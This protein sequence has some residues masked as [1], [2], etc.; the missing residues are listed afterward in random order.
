MQFVKELWTAKIVQKWVDLRNSKLNIPP[1]LVLL[2]YMQLAR[3]YLLCGYIQGVLMHLF[4]RD[5]HIKFKI[6]AEKCN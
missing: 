5:Q 1:F 3:K 4:I 2:S 6:I